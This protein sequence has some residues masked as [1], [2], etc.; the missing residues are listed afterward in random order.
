MK[1]SQ[2][3]NL[4][5]VIEAG[6]V[7]QAARNLNV[8][9]SAVTKSI[10]QLEELLGTELLLRASHGV[11]A[12]AAGDALARRAKVIEAE[13]RQARND[14]EAV[15]GAATG[16]IRIVASPTV[17]M[18]LL[19]KAIVN[20]KKARPGVN[21]QI[22]EGLYP[23]VLPSIRTGDIDFAVCLV[24]ERPRDED[25]NF[26][27]LVR[28]Q[29][30]PAVRAGHP[31]TRVKKIALE[32]L[33]DVG[34]VVYQRSRTGRDIF[35]QTFALNDLEPPTNMTKSTSFACTLALVEQSDYVTLVPR[36][37][38][39]GKIVGG[40]ITPL[41]LETSMPAWNV[42]VI[43]RAK[44]ALSPLCAA[45]LEDLHRTEPSGG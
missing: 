33:V 5:A 12:T 40:A 18:G 42:M 28:D 37:I 30:T 2:L 25:L 17:M 20:F 23:D 38:F 8:S 22:E 35:E 9:Q 7:R 41:N 13:L 27:L 43:S 44:H 3:R 34:W 10:K 14:I 16:E 24:P 31:L 6:S 15:Q 4:V 45:F 11:S 32:D 21:F 26:D 1:L 19:P 39:A 29:L 36:K